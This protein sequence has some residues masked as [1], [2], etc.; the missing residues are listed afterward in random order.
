MIDGGIAFDQGGNLFPRMSRS[1]LTTL[2]PEA[3]LISETGKYASYGI[4][5]ASI[6][7]RVFDI[8]ATFDDDSLWMVRLLDRKLGGTWS[9]ISDERLRRSKSENDHWVLSV[10]GGATVF[11]WGTIKSVFDTKNA[12]PE[13]V[14][15][16]HPPK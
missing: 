16:Y 8:V 6:R 9:D 2:V 7:G 1:S 14:L 5:A 12:L 10:T 3:C 4:E 11:P 15:T 13:V